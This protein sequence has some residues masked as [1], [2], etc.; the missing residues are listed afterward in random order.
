MAQDED[1]LETILLAI[2]IL[3]DEMKSVSNAYITDTFID[4]YT[5]LIDGDYTDDPIALEY[6]TKVLKWNDFYVS[7][8]VTDIQNDY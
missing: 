8:L 1:D 3:N 4:E 2:L 6:L 5:K 7:R